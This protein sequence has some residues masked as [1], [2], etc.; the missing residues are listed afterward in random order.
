M[1]E[2]KEAGDG[3]DI[4]WIMPGQLS[5]DLD[6]AILATNVGAT[7]DVVSVSSDGTYLLRVIAEDTKTP[8]EDQV[9]IIKDNGFSYWY[10]QKKTAAT[11]DY[12]LGSSSSTG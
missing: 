12:N 7:S 10:T 2:G 3:G 9:K 6:K 4:G 8:T 5:D 11:I 1:S